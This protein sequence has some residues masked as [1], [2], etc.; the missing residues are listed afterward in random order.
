MRVTRMEKRVILS[1]KGAE[2]TD[3]TPRISKVEVFFNYIIR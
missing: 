3:L 2:R 1:E